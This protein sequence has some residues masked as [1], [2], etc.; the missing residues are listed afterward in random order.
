MAAMLSSADEHGLKGLSL[1]SRLRQVFSLMSPERLKDL[2]ARVPDEAR[3]QGLVYL[4]E[5]KV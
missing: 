1:D 3:E 4:R 5:G 2:A